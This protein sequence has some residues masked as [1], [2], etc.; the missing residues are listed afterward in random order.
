MFF[1]NVTSLPFVAVPRNDRKKRGNG[2]VLPTRYAVDPQ[3]DGR[4]ESRADKL[5]TTGLLFILAPTTD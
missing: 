3:T 2:K 1:F 5:D 4:T